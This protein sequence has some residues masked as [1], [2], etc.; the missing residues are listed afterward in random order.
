MGQVTKVACFSI[1]GKDGST[2][3]QT[4]ILLHV[5]LLYMSASRSFKIL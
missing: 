5:Y 3:T 2:A 4:Q 1:G